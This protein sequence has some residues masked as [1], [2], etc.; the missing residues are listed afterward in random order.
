MATTS[1]PKNVKRKANFNYVS[2]NYIRSVNGNGISLTPDK[3]Y[4]VLHDGIT[5]KQGNYGA[6]LLVGNTSSYIEFSVKE[7]CRFWATSGVYSDG[8]GSSGKVLDIYK[9]DSKLNT[10]SLYKSVPTT[11]TEDWYI[12][13]ELLTIGIYKIQAQGNYIQF[14]EFYFESIVENKTFILHDGEYK[15]Y[16]NKS[17]NTHS[18]SSV[19]PTMTSN[20]NG[21]ITLSTN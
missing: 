6:L 9:Y 19:I 14:N 21:K 1:I 2:S 7:N 13:C 8:G 11:S 10:Y 5:S 15:K 16:Q 3:I 17:E 4:E 18:S 12:V 20:T